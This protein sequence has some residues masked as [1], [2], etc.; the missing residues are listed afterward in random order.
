[1]TASNVWKSINKMKTKIIFTFYTIDFRFGARQ[2]RV[3]ARPL[4]S[5]TGVLI[6]C[7]WVFFFV[8]FVLYKTWKRFADFDTGTIGL[9]IICGR[10][11]F[12]CA[13]TQE[14]FPFEFHYDGRRRRPRRVFLLPFEQPPR[15]PVKSRPSVHRKEQP[16]YN[17]WEGIKRTPVDRVRRVRRAVRR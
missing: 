15:P 14:K 1:M 7:C 6:S 8:V 3:L 17:L 16:A 10:R 2:V 13:G 11:T 5:N 9:D 4:I 12:R